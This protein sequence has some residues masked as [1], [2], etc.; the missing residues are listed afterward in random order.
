MM[1]L[2]VPDPSLVV[3][4]GPA[5]SGKS[6]FAARHFTDTV[7][8]SSD[9]C[10]AMITDDEA[11][12][13]VSADAFDLFR[14]I[15]DARLRYRRLAVAD[16]TA[17]HAEARKDLVRIARRRGVPAVLIVFDVTEEAC[18]QWNARRGRVV[19]DEVIH[20]Q[21]LA[22]EQALTQVGTEGFAQVAVLH[23]GDVTDA[24]VEIVAQTGG[25]RHVHTHHP[26]G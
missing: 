10:R 2:S 8:V 3:L 17:L 13:R 12:L 22:L 25:E 26:R 20:R 18:R 7:V 21:H 6:T 23:A 14:H 9:R 4:C 5:G 1:R 24:A 15:I 11:D 19:S 16:S